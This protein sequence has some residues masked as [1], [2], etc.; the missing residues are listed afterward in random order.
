MYAMKVLNKVEMTKRAEKACYKE[1]RDILVNSSNDWFTKL[2]YAFQ[3][4]ENLYLIMDYYIGG[5]IV[6]SPYLIIIT[7]L[8]IH[9]SIG[10]FLTLLMKYDDTLPEDM[11]RFYAAEIIL[12]ISALHE[13]GYIHRDIKPPNIL[14]DLHGHIRL[15]DFGSCVRASTVKS[16]SSAPVGTPDYV[17]P[18]ILDVIEGKNRND[19]PYSYETDWWSLG[20]VLFELFYGQTPFY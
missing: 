17:S 3:D 6:L 19:C 11:C 13:L 7:V 18:E 10:D 5:L 12:G 1:E 8:I 16:D 15:G 4:S 9:F 20:I 14:I 2:Y